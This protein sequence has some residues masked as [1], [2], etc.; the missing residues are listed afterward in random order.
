MK[1]RLLIL[2]ALVVVLAVLFAR[3]VSTP[4]LVEGDVSEVATDEGND[5]ERI[6]LMQTSLD[7]RPLPGEEPPEEPELDVQVEVNTAIGK[8]RLDYYI[9]EAHGYYVETFRIDFWY[10]EHPDMGPEESPLRFEHYL[11]DYVEANKTKKD[12]IEVV[13]AEL[14]RVG[15]EIG[16]TE[17]WGARVV[18]HGRA[19]MKNPDPLPPVARV[20]RCD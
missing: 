15:G 1:P 12:C 19:R 7:K 17:N 10:K 2:L 20:R 5:L 3:R 4:T 18:W 16:T 13:P 11:D 9:S 8:N 6:R 14:S